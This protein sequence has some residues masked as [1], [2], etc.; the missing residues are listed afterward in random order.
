LTSTF[1]SVPLVWKFTLRSLPAWT[2]PVP[3]T[4]DWTTPFAA[5][6][7]CVDVRA[8]LVGGPIWAMAKTTMASA[9]AASTYRYQGRLWRSLMASLT[10]VGGRGDD[11]ASP[12]AG[13]TQ[14]IRHR[15]NLNSA[16]E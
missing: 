13:V 15:I 14:A 8:E 4:V 6:T 2:F 9:A 7:I 11:E 5:V 10:P 12:R 16:P 1:A 3:D